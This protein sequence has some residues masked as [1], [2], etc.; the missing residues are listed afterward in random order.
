MSPKQ[1]PANLWAPAN[2]SL[3]LLLTLT[4]ILI[5]RETSNKILA[6]EPFWKNP[7][8]I[9]KFSTL[10]L[11]RISSIINPASHLEIG[12]S[13]FI[14]YLSERSLVAQKGFRHWIGSKCP[15]P[16]RVFKKFSHWCLWRKDLESQALLFAL[17]DNTLGTPHIFNILKRISC[18]KG[19]LELCILNTY[20]RTRTVLISRGRQ[21]NTLII[22]FNSSPIQS[23]LTQQQILTGILRFIFSSPSCAVFLPPASS[24]KSKP[25]AGGNKMAVLQCFKINMIQFTLQK[26]LKLLLHVSLSHNGKNISSCPIEKK[27]EKSTTYLFPALSN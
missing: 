25:T 2:H 6:S 1:I 9:Y 14:G 26:A 22:S 4:F 15:I 19:I 11:L 27:S 24:W 3:V 17:C 16:F 18:G 21:Y 5:N 12:S 20:R 13:E 10:L 8:M 7:N 23:L